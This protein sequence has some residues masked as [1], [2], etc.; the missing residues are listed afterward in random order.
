MPR[1]KKTPAVKNTTKTKDQ[2]ALLEFEEFVSRKPQ[3]SNNR[4]WMFFTLLILVVLLGIAWAFTWNADN[5]KKEYK[6][7]A[8][9]LE[10]DQVYYA[11][12]VREDSQNIYLDDVY[13]IQVEQQTIPAQEEG[14]DPT[15]VSV[16]VLVKRGQE[17]HQ[18]T[19]WMQLNRDKVIAIEEIGSDSE[20]LKEINRQE[21]K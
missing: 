7:K 18:P 4:I 15:V 21:A 8:V 2:E 20:V 19:G 12:V 5:L 17:I 9:Y 10:N 3:K 13:Y 11:K 1:T 6:F 14:A 16:P